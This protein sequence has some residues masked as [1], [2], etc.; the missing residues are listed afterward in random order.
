MMA[1]L[2]DDHVPAY[3]AGTVTCTTPGCENQ[4]VPIEVPPSDLVVC[5]G[6]CNVLLT[7]VPF[8]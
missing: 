6:G 8:E 5:G 2:I 3:P 4:G 7:I 1:D